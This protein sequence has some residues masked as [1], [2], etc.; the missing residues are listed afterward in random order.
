MLRLESLANFGL[1]SL[2]LNCRTDRWAPLHN[3][4]IIF[5]LTLFHSS[6]N[7]SVHVVVRLLS[8]LWL[9]AFPV[10]VHRGKRV[11]FTTHLFCAGQHRINDGS[12]NIAGDKRLLFFIWMLAEVLFARDHALFKWGQLRRHST[13][14]KAASLALINKSRSLCS[15]MIKEVGTAPR[16]RT[17]SEIVQKL[18]YWIA[19][20]NLVSKKARRSEPSVPARFDQC[21]E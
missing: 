8:R 3:F 20:S 10:R 18:I 9:L 13:A 6:L 1:S 7:T 5:F 15:K 12:T 16:S 21:C 11:N 17:A 2:R 19:I 4:Q 14:F